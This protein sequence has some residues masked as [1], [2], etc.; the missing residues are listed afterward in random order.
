MKA[1][2]RDNYIKMG[3][4]IAYYRKYKNLTQEALAELSGLSI[5]YI[6]QI[7]AP[8]IYQSFSFDVLFRIAKV[9]EI[10]PHKI[11]EFD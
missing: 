9:L 4:K 5:S 1:E 10:P 6:G 2:F 7:E 11:L 8:N 3:L